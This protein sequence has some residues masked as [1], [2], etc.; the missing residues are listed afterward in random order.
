MVEAIPDA[1]DAAAPRPQP[2]APAQAA[3]ILVAEDNLVN[4]KLALLMLK[5]MGYQADVVANGREAYDAQLVKN[6]DLILMD[7]QMPVMDGYAATKALRDNAKTC[8][9]RIVA[10]TA[11]AMDGDRDKCLAAGMDDYITKPVRME[12]LKA[13]LD[14]HFPAQTP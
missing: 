7:C 1:E 10:M 14:R 9:V 2:A 8:A 4:Q 11:H 6:Y 5:K 13:I 3:R 12:D